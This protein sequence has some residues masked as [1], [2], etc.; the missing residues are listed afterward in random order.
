MTQPRP[1]CAPT[2]RAPTFNDLTESLRSGLKDFSTAPGLGLFFASFFVLAGL[3]MAGITVLTGTTYWLILAVMGYP[4][5]GSL[6]ALGFYETSKRL[7]EDDDVSFAAITRSVWSQ[8]GGQLPWLAAIIVVVFLFWFF[9]GHMIFALFLGLS[10]MTNVLSTL[11][12][13]LSPNGLMMLGFGTAVGSVFAMI[14][15]AMSVLGMPMLLDRDVDFVTA[16]ITSIGAVVGKPQV[17]L[18]WGISVAVITLIA[19]LPFFLGLFVAMPIL[20]HASWH[21]YQRVTTAEAAAVQN[22]A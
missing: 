22:P 1:H 2:L 21:L 3:L 20:G 7:Q 10:P 5:V 16:I 9:L 4:L 17:Y 15:F 8:R 18:I 11:D 19:M 13:F 14:V 6:A 12:V